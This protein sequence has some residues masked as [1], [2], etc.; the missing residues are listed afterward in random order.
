MTAVWSAE[1]AAP[2][3]SRGVSIPLAV[4]SLQIS[5]IWYSEGVISPLTPIRSAEHSAAFSRIVSLGTMTPR[6]TISNPLQL[7]TISVMFFPMSCTS[8]LTVANTIRGFFTSDSPPL[9]SM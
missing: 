2:P 9:S 8:P 6:S 7:S 5:S 3:T 1:A 4:I